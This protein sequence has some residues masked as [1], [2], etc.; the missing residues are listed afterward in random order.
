MKVQLLLLAVISI[1]L[2][3]CGKIEKMNRM[4]DESTQAIHCNRIAVE[5]STATIRENIHYIE[6]SNKAIE[7]N[8][9]HLESLNAE[10]QK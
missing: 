4:V 8:R 2:P 6:E 9:K 10:A 3:G 5:H 7:E 1:A